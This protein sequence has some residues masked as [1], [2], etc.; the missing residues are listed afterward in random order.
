MALTIKSIPPNLYVLFNNRRWILYEFPTLVV[1]W[2]IKRGSRTPPVALSVALTG[3][4]RRH[5]KHQCHL[6]VRP[7]SGHELASHGPIPRASNKNAAQSREPPAPHRKRRARPQ[8]P[9]SVH[10]HRAVNTR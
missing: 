9:R 8:V 7:V 2:L 6:P 3:L 4:T 10:S 5:V 1:R